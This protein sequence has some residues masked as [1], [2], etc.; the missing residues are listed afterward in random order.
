[1]STVIWFIGFALMMASFGFLFS[2]SEDADQPRI[3]VE[4]WWP[5]VDSK[6]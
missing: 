5:D 6:R 1:M 3:S 4:P 2:R